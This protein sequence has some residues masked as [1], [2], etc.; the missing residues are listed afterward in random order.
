MLGKISSG[1]KDKGIKYVLKR[2][3]DAYKSKSGGPLVGRVSEEE[4]R[5]VIQE[6]TEKSFPQEGYES[7]E[8]ERSTKYPT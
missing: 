3:S 5:E 6:I 1:K 2:K 7:F 8:L 4:E